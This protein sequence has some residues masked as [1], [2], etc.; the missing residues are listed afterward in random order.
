MHEETGLTVRGCRLRGVVSRHFTG[1]APD[2]VVE[3]Y[4][5][6]GIVFDAQVGDG[7]PRVV[8]VDGTTAD[9]RW[10][11][12]AELPALPTVALVGAARRLDPP[13]D[14]RPTVTP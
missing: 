14:P 3:D 5:G 7:E 11:R 10:V 1:A 12:L 2:G 13:P 8:E 6:V 9:A 4:H